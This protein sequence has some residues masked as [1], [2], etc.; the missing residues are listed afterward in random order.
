[1]HFI[2]FVK[3]EIIWLSLRRSWRADSEG[4]SYKACGSFTI[5]LLDSF[6]KSYGKDHKKGTFTKE[7]LNALS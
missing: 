6:L 4:K 2:F 7:T 5:L 1:M 3:Y